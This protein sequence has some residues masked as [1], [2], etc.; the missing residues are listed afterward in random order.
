MRRQRVSRN[1]VRRITPNQEVRENCAVIKCRMKN[2]NLLFALSTLSLLSCS[3][4]IPLTSGT[5]ATTSVTTTVSTSDLCTVTGSGDGNTQQPALSFE[6]LNTSATPANPIDNSAFAMPTEAGPPRHEFSGRLELHD[7]SLS[8][9]DNHFAEWWLPDGQESS[10]IPEFDY[11][12]VQCGDSLLPVQRGRI[13]TDNP[14]WDLLL[15]PGRAWSTPFDEGMSRASFPFALTM[16][17]ENCVQNGLMTFLYDDD[18]VSDVRWQITQETCH[19]HMFDMWGQSAA[20]YHPAVIPES[21]QV[22]NLSLIHI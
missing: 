20:T 2:T 3:N 8:Q 15:H 22:I 6:T 5:T 4:E 14:Y 16:K 11:E 18:S 12:F 19:F 10:T 13:L 9:I 1:T 21:D 7:E 17:A